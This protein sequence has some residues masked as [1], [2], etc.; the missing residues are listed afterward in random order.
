MIWLA[1]EAPFAACRPM[2]AGWYRPT[3]GFLT[4]SAVYGLIL[5]VAGVETRLGE[6]EP[7]HPGDVPASVTRAGLPTFRLALGLPDGGDLPR[8]GTVFQQLHNYS[9]GAGNAGI[10]PEHALGRKNNI[11]PV[12]REFLSEVRALAAVQAEEE[13]LDRIRG[14]LRG[15]RNGGRYGLPFLGDNNFTLDRLEEV[16]P[17]RGRWFAL[18]DA[19]RGERPRAGTTRLT[20]FIDR[21]SPTGT[22]SGLFSPSEEPSTS[23]PDSALV[24]VGDPAAFDDWAR[25][26]L[27]G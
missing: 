11:A 17:C 4:H 9:V 12:R 24:P 18:T 25:R 14:G 15:E 27:P 16:G 5:N 2:M 7:G 1:I 10:K 22:R 26:H 3:A 20:T 23:P 21:S 19:G 6:H 13:L 8:V